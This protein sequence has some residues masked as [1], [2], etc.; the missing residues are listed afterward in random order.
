MSIP[1]KADFEHARRKAEMAAAQPV[2][3][4][5]GGPTLSTIV[6]GVTVGVFFGA[7]LFVITF[8][9]LGYNIIN[10]A[11]ERKPT[12]SWTYPR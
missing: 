12:E 3:V 6:I 1:S 10:K 5:A 7:W 4:L 9:W 11:F 2:R 8:S